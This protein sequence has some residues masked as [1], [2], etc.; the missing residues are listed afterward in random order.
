[1]YEA[2]A[3]QAYRQAIQWLRD[4]RPRCVVSGA[5]LCSPL[6][7]DAILTDASFDSGLSMTWHLWQ[8]FLTRAWYMLPVLVGGAL[9]IYGWVERYYAFWDPSY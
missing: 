6:H 8:L 9:E 7:S 3:N 2:E 1:M 5:K 4:F